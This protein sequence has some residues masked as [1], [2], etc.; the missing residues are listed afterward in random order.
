MADAERVGLSH[1]VAVHAFLGFT[2]MCSFPVHTDD[3]LEQMDGLLQI[4]H[5]H[6]VAFIKSRAH[7]SK[8]GAPIPHFKIPKSH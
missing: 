1:L 3:L 8:D 4:W 7:C 6:K 2:M 5:D